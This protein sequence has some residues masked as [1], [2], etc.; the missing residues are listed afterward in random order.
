MDFAHKLAESSWSQSEKQLLISGFKRFTPNDLDGVF[1]GDIWKRGVVIAQSG[2]DFVKQQ[3]QKD[4]PL[5]IYVGYSPGRPHL[6]YLVMRNLLDSFRNYGNTNILLGVNAQESMKTHGRSL[7]ETLRIGEIVERVLL[8][9]KRM[10]QITK[11]YDLSHLNSPDIQENYSKV[12]SEVSGALSATDFKKIMGWSEETPLSEYISLLSAI[13]GMLYPSAKSTEDAS[14]VFTD[15]KHLPFVRMAK[16]VA[17]KMQVREPSFL[18]TNALPSLSDGEKRM[19]SLGGA[20]TL[21]LFNEGEYDKFLKVRTG[22]RAKEEQELYGGNP[23][24]C[25][26]L[27]IAAFIINSEE[28]DQTLNACLS[29]KQSSCRECKS[30]MKKH[31]KKEGESIK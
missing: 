24:S 5:T 10:R 25:L 31:I 8:G 26:A 13:T 3:V 23:A 30:I 6:G 17:N 12:Y 2:F 15:I 29:G 28:T 22:G 18:V 21:Y 7:E 27:K 14:L 11:I 1:G 19:S 9:D 20:S 16:K 4:Y